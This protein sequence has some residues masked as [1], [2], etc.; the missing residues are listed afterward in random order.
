M[1]II[2]SKQ[3]RVFID[4]D[5]LNTCFLFPA[6]DG[7]TCG[8]FMSIHKALYYERIKTMKNEKSTYDYYERSAKD[9]EDRSE[10]EDR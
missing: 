2:S 3:K 4:I 8:I 1:R 6:G 5:T 9:L 10:D 7:R